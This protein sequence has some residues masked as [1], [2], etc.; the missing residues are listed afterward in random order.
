M[1]RVK[2]RGVNSLTG[3]YGEFGEDIIFFC[4]C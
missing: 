3:P 2:R 1:A 4:G